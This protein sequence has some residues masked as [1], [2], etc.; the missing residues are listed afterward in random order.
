VALGGVDAE[1]APGER[2]GVREEVVERADEVLVRR[3]GVLQSSP[4]DGAADQLLGKRGGR[5][6]RPL[7][8]GAEPLLGEEAPSPS[9]VKRR[10]APPR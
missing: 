6:L 2:L 10:R 1:Q 7:R 8:R 5:A 9:S 4:Q 3:F